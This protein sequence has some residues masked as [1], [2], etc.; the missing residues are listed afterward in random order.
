MALLDLFLAGVDTTQFTLRW[1]LLLLAD[2][3]DWQR[4]LRDEVAHSVG[5][6]VATLEDKVSFVLKFLI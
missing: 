6:R 3:P 5:G 2:K 4:R 1:L